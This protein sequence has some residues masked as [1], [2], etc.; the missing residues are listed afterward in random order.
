LI[1][2]ISVKV[3]RIDKCP[4]GRSNPRWPRFSMV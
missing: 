4:R 3:E 1:A 2:V